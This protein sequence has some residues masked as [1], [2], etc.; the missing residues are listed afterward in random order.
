[1]KTLSDRL[2]ETRGHPSGFDYMRVGLALA[3]LALH[4]GL[5]A[6]G[7]EG[8][9]SAEGWLVHIYIE[10]ALVPCFFALSGFLVAGSYER[11]K[12]IFNFIG[13]RALRIFPAVIV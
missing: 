2:A 12:T 6:H 5:A 13:L 11:S 1:M 10:T 9:K 7:S 4:A 3:I 8:Y